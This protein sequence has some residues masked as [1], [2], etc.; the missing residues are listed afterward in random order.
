VLVDSFHRGNASKCAWFSVSTDLYLEAQRDL[1]ALGCNAR[2]I[3]GLQAI[4]AITKNK[5]WSVRDIPKNYKSYSSRH[6][7]DSR[8]DLGAGLGGCGND[9]V[10]L[11]VFSLAL[12]ER[13]HVHD[14]LLTRQAHRA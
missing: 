14:V 11:S 10:C 8:I 13:L 3:N 12:Q 1:A 6:T 2:V 5:N 7:Q 9:A 4:D